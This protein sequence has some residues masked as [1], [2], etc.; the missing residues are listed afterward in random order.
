MLMAPPMHVRLH[1]PARV[2]ARLLNCRRRPLTGSG[3]RRWTVPDGQ[4]LRQSALLARVRLAECQHLM[5]ARVRRHSSSVRV[6]TK[7]TQCKT[8]CR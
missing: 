3:F 4:R 5:H 2:A 1:A 7:A 8:G 6:I